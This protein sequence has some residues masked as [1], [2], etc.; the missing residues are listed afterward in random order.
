[1]RRRQLV[2]RRESL[3]GPEAEGSAEIND[4]KA[5]VEE[6]RRDFRR[7]FVRRG[8]KGR[9]GAASFDT[10]DGKGAKRGFAGAA[11]LGKQFGEAVLT[12]GFANVEE[13]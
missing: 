3:G 7:D 12:L 10:G 9:S 13:R 8:E 2:P 6:L 11:E 4:A 1:M 5:G